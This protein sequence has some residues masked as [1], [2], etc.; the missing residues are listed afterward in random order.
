M[1]DLSLIWAVIIALGV[2]IYVVLDGFD[3]GIGI[4]FPFIKDQQE[5]DVMMNTVAPVWDGNETWMVLG[6]AGLFGA[7]P[8][9]Y[10]TLLSA[11]YMPIMLMLVALIFRGVAFEFRFKAHRSKPVWDMAF[12]GGSTFASFIQGVILGG[13]IQGVK[14]ENGLYVGGGLDWLTP[15]SLFTGIGVVVMYAAL[16]CGWL[17]MKT[18]HEL[19]DKMYRLMPK[20]VIAVLLLIAAVSLYTP[21][22]HHTIAQKWFTTPQ[23]YYFMPVPL[24]VIL[25][26]FLAWKSCFTRD[27]FKP[28]F[29]TLCIMFLAYTGFIISLW[30]NIIPPSLTIWQAA[31]PRDSQLFALIGALVLIPIILMYTIM[32]Y[33]VFRDKVRVG[34]EGYH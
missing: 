10:G 1:I 26:G 21:F 33:W 24:L 2:L 6:G 16:G 4:L 13:Y 23:L 9:V 25:F 5:R 28:F 22:A 11:F 31:A 20:L 7:F 17:I 30:P 14:T 3:L 32:G 34:D 12:I 19:Q 15:F 27:D 29:Y 8:V 18:D